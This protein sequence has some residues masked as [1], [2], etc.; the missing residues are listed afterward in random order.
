MLFESE[1][2]NILFI[3][4][5]LSTLD[6]FFKFHFGSFFHNSFPVFILF[7]IFFPSLQLIW[8]IFL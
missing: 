3:L 8:S 7:N 2:F 6:K 5:F 4:V 1:E